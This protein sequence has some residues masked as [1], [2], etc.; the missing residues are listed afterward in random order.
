LILFLVGFIQIYWAKFRGKGNVTKGLYKFIRH[1]QYAALAIV[2]LGA[3][4]YW[5]RFIVL[6]M[7]ATMLFLYYYLARQEEK[8]CFQKFGDS[9]S[10]YY[11]KTGMFLPR[12]IENRLPKF[13]SFLPKNGIKRGLS[14]IVIYFCYIICIAG[15]G[16]LLK[17][18]ALSQTT[19]LSD[20]HQA[21]VSV[22]PIKRERIQR[23]LE[24]VNTHPQITQFLSSMK[25][26]RKLIYVIPCE[27]GIPELGLKQR[28]KSQNYLLHPETHGNSLKF[29]PDHL[30]VLI[31]EP[32]LHSPDTEGI[33]I[34]KKSLSFI[35]HLEV[36]VDLKSE[37]VKSIKERI[38]QGRWD[39]IPV[40]IY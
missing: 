36:Y 4:I 33:D 29:N 9:Y 18:Y 22:A 25:L 35:S 19:V 2:G 20:N 31:T 1:P 27:W 40:P 7:Y 14:I 28:G 34:L 5:S 32:V 17:N 38:N 15:G 11:K 6:L 30:I 10:T 23:A 16:F 3:T 12:F 8:I 13:P 39:G 21:V 24:I 26:S 37:E